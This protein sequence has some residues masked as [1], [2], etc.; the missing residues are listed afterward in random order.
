MSTD[1]PRLMSI[2]EREGIVAPV[3]DL[4]A[5]QVAEALD[6]LAHLRAIA[7]GRLPPPPAVAALG[8]LLRP[9]DVHPGHVTFRL[10]P[11]TAHLNGMGM[12]HGGVIATLV[13]TALGT[14]IQTRLAPGMGVTTID[15]QVRYLRPIF[16][17]QTP[18]MAVG[19][20]I[21]V[22][23]QLATAEARVIDE[24]GRLYAHATTTCMLLPHG[25]RLPSI[26]PVTSDADQG[27]PST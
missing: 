16:A 4:P 15:L 14:T 7:E 18:V 20:V 5:S 21:N 8:I 27:S 11:V 13:D 10:Q 12:V 9:E 17:G 1:Q 2:S 25:L 3:Q 22:S 19:E 26:E 23:R 24:Q 6:G